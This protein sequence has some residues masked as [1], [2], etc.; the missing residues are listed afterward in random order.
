MILPSE[1]HEQ[2]HG[3]SAFTVS[4]VLTG[5]AIGGMAVG[6]AVILAPHILPAIGIGS[7]DMAEESMFILH[8]S[9]EAGGTG[10]AG[11]LNRS[12]AAVP[13]IGEKL[14]AG[15]LF[16]AAATATVGIG[17]VLLGNFIA[18]R[19][20]GS[21]RIKWGNVIKYAALATSAMIALPT[22]LTAL[23]TGLIFLSTLGSNIDFALSVISTVDKT[24]GT[25]GVLD[26]AL[27][28][29]SGVAAVIPHFLTCGVAMVP[30]ALTL[31]LWRSKSR[32]AEHS[33]AAQAQQPNERH[34]RKYSDGSIALSIKTLEPP[35][36]NKLCRALLTLHRRDTGAL[37]TADELAVVHTEKLHLFVVDDSLK[38]YHHVH[39]QPTGNPGE[40]AFSFTPKTDHIYQAWADFTTLKDGRNHKL[41]AAIASP[42][43][44]RAR[45]HITA[46]RHAETAGLRFDWHASGPLQAEQPGIVEVTVTDKHGRPVTDLEPVMDAFAH[47]VGFSADGKSIIHTHPLGGEPKSPGARGGPSLRFHVE[48][49]AS[50]PMQF[51][52]QVKRGGEDIYA[53]FGQQVQPPAKAT[54][55]IAQARHHSEMSLSRY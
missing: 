33:F 48:P 8:T 52:V 28:G 38:D 20:D 5:L 29:F 36:A 26:N 34:I 2:K 12:L 6:A 50:G 11:A 32:H 14:A 17:G 4:R 22:V 44:R 27:M 43:S 54:E 35:V 18:K 55:R 46:S 15:G 39:P 21:K 19:E 40:L 1:H 10:V 3:H 42:K 13:L 41:L 51:Y 31:G 53:P 37:L 30:A 7:V 9:A 47:M 25:A 23:S 45:P 49:D 16:N 24:L